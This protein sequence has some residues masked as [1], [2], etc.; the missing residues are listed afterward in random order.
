[1]SVHYESDRNRF[2]V[3]WRE[4]G[5]QRSRR[6]A[7]E[8][9]AIAFD[10]E[11]RASSQPPATTSQSPPSASRDAIYAY[12]TKSWSALPLRVSPI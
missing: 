7:S 6:F 11:R 4:N 9:A 3:R 1:M 2:V 5:K 8:T 10:Q 12:A